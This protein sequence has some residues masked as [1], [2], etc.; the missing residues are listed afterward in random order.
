M[1]SAGLV[2]NATFATWLIRHCVQNSCVLPGSCI[3]PIIN[4]LC[5][6]TAVKGKEIDKIC[7]YC[8]VLRCVYTEYDEIFRTYSDVG[9][10]T[11]RGYGVKLRH[12]LRHSRTVLRNLFLLTAHENHV[13]IFAAHL[14]KKEQ[15][16]YTSNH[17]NYSSMGSTV[18]WDAWGCRN[19]LN[20]CML[21]SILEMATRSSRSISFK[22]DRS[23]FLININVEK[24]CSHKYFMQN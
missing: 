5:H 8:A 10:E 21:G 14:S 6:V 11:V 24:L 12:Y 19:E 7:Q 2:A 15:K 18:Q 1:K 17:C 3:V 13:Q 20:R 4:A 22:H 16:I 9:Y 23:S